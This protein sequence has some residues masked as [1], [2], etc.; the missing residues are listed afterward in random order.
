M[1]L[2]RNANR[3]GRGGDAAIHCRLVSGLLR[4]C[5]TKST[6]SAKRA[7]S[8]WRRPPR[9]R[10]QPPPETGARHVRHSMTGRAA[11][12]PTWVLVAVTERSQAE[13]CRDTCW[14]P[15]GW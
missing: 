1:R 14:Q 8:W 5:A 3:G 12:Q 13:C 7:P 10:Q 4:S 9:A 2:E 6:L 11:A 15:A